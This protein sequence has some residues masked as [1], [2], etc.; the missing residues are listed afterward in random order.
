MIMEFE[1]NDEAIAAVQNTSP[2]QVWF[3]VMSDRSKKAV[4]REAHIAMEIAKRHARMIGSC[5]RVG[6]VVGT[7]ASTM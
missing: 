7:K 6:R 5:T 4:V 1:M 3:F 2:S